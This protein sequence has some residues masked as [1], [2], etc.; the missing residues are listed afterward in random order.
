MKKDFSSRPSEPKKR[1][2]L[3]E[4]SEKEFDETLKRV[5]ELVEKVMEEMNKQIDS[6][7]RE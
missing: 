2:E 3:E 1:S 6:N 4:E 5:N 7:M